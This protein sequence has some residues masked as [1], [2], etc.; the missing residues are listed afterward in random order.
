MKPDNQVMQNEEH[1]YLERTALG[2]HEAF[3]SIFMKYFPKVKYFIV[4]IVKSEELAEDLS[5]DIFFKIWIS[6][7]YLP[8]LRSFNAYIY[9]MAKHAAL[10]H[11]EHKY[12]EDSYLANYSS[13]SEAATPEEELDA[14]ELELLIQIA[15]DLMP[16]QRRK[17]Y[18]MSRV[19]N[20]KNGK[21]AEILRL[22]E[23]TV[24]NQLSLALKEIRKIVTLASLFFL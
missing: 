9:K 3:R 4:H 10:N 22:S 7:E 15:I 14:K 19:E 2:D 8:N 18:I 17:I 24:N 20:I 23:K 11:L 16:E 1:N 6:K 12:V 5:Q 13:Q 21:I